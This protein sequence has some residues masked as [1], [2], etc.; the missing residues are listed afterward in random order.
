MKK[1]ALRQFV[2][3]REQLMREKA[4]LER[5]LSEINEALGALSPGECGITKAASPES[6]AA[7]PA[8]VVRRRA[9]TAARPKATAGQPSLRE[10]FLAATSSGPLTRHELIE[11][12]MARGYRF[13]SK[14]PL[15]SLS[16]FLY[17][18]KSVRNHGGR[19]GPA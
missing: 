11:A 10:A 2:A 4:G 13:K 5:R 18:D 16:A 17:T 8:P 15:N 3:L 7:G 6:D 1:D 14:N 9:K 12:V 19:F